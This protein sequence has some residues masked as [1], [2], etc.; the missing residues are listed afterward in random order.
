MTRSASPLAREIERVVTNGLC[1]GCGGC[2]RLDP[3][4][5]MEL[6][7]GFLRPELSRL[8]LGPS[9]KAKAKQFKQLCPGLR[10]P[11]APKSND[12]TDNPV[13]GRSLAVFASHATDPKIRKAGSSGGTLTGLAAWLVESGRADRVFA[14][15]ESSSSRRTTVPVT[16]TSKEEALAAAGSR[17]C[18]ASCLAGVP[19]QLNQRDVVIGKPCEISAL[20]AEYPREAADSP[21]LF[22]FFCAGTP[23]LRATDGLLEKHGIGAEEPLTTLRYRGDGWPGFFRG[24]TA[25]GRVATATYNESWGAHLG[26]TMQWRCKLCADGVG[27]SADL[28]CA[29]FWEADP[30]GYPIFEEGDGTSALVVRTGRG[31]R[32]VEE[33]TEAGAIMTSRIAPAALAAVQP[34]QHSKRTQVFARLVGTRLAGKLT[35]RYLGY[36]LFRKQEFTLRGFYAHVRATWGRAKRLNKDNS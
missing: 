24:E 35:P 33:A 12:H 5:R 34:G 25:D 2:A 14:V 29:D 16:I 19:E 7:E 32:V 3:N 10:V 36:G 27:E 6:R 17:Y 8:S 23:N 11:S 1:S 9:A 4:I 31:R 22:S 20:R 26:P 13:V 28:A 18:P 15:A 30:E 21:L